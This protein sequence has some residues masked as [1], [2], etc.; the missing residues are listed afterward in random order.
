[1]GRSTNKKELDVF[2]KYRIIH[3]AKGPGAMPFSFLLVGGTSLTLL[4]FADTSRKNYFSSRIGYY[5]QAIIVTKFYE[6]FTL[7]FMPIVV[8][9]NLVPINYD[10]YVLLAFGTGVCLIFIRRILL[11]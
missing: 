3:Q 2:A 10:S 1:V 9:R 4:K 11:I 5:A 8:H 6:R 7:Q